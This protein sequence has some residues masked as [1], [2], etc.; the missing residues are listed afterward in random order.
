MRAA[1]RLAL[2]LIFA[3]L[4]LLPND[5]A[6]APAHGIAMHGDLRYP[7]DFRHFD[8]VNPDAPKG[9]RLN[10]S[11]IGTFDSLNPFII[12][13][14]APTGLRDYVFESLLT[15]SRD[16]AFSLYGLLAE[17]VELAENG[18]SVTFSLNPS[19]TF[20]DG[21]PVTIDDIEF[22]WAVQREK[23]RPNSRIYYRKVV[24]IE[25]PAPGAI[26]FVFEDAT[27]R[28]LPLILGLMPILPKHRYG[29]GRFDAATLEAP[30]GSG[31]YATEAVKP[32][33]EITYRRRE[34]YWGKDLPV[35]RGRYNFDAI[36]VLYFRDSNS[37]FESFKK[38]L[39][40]VQ[41]DSD[42]TRWTTGYDFPAARRGEVVKEAFE[43]QLPAPTAAFVFNTRRPPFSDIRVREA[44]LELFDFSWIN[45]NLY[46]DLF[47]RTDSFYSGSELSSADRPASPEERVLLAEYPDAVLPAIMD[48]RYRLPGGSITGRDR[49]SQKRALE[50]LSQAGYGIDRGSL[51]R[52]DSGE[53]LSFE[54]LTV[55]RDQE[56]LA[57]AY[58]RSLA[59]IGVTATVRQVDS[60]QF[61]KRI[62]TYDFD[63]MPYTWYNSL[64][65]GNEQAFYWGSFGAD[66]PGTRNYMGAKAP[67]IDPLIG[68]MIAART[69]A[70]LVTATRALDR[71]LRS[72]IYVVPLFYAPAQWV[73]RWTPIEHPDVTPLYGY[74]IDS[75]W[76]VPSP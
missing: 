66:H 21:T 2:L 24:A 44:L 65:P 71:V 6:A 58:S 31:P 55:T 37:A 34:D 41:A 60:S 9:G 73:G 28:E 74:Q 14:L 35:N 23:G 38:G 18:R 15:R 51:R 56:R 32:G 40:D 13:G 49:D 72:G 70:E 46:Y 10:L 4:P 68:A 17:S 43:T 61:Q 48:G 54:L 1:A 22:S 8:Y 69:R 11:A 5:L 75:W 7:A 63:M 3:L 62:E 20:S 42:P 64:S 12:R 19:A 50:L 53:P 47:E 30:V 67:A 33:A 52:I 29:E 39:V 57:L 45:K 59:K 27:D 26:T 36:R 16:E 76:A 25:R